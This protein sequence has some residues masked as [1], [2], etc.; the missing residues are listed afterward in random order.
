MDSE[1]VAWLRE[2]PEVCQEMF[3]WLKRQGAIV[4]DDGRWRGAEWRDGS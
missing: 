3:N 2:Q 4:Y 1:V